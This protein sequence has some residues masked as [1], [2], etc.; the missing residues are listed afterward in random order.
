[1]NHKFYLKQ[2]IGTNINIILFVNWILLVSIPLMSFIIV[3]LKFL[4]NRN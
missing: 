2:T 1:M 4:S 3:L